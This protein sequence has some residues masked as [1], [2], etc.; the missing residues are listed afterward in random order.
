MRVLTFDGARPGRP[1]ARICLDAGKPGFSWPRPGSPGSPIN[2]E[3]C[4][5]YSKRALSL[6]WGARMRSGKLDPKGVVYVDSLDAAWKSAGFRGPGYAACRDAA[7]TRLARE[8][9]H[10]SN[11]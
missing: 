3:D 2:Y 8:D 9:H 10:R 4:I 5:S 1:G 6:P 7:L 11:F